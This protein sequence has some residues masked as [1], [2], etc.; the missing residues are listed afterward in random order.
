MILY[1]NDLDS[2]EA[3]SEEVTEE[4]TEEV[5]EDVSE[6]STQEI[7]TEGDAYLIV[8]QEELN[9]AVETLPKLYNLF[10]FWFLCWIFVQVLLRIRRQFH[11]HT[12]EID[13]K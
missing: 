9:L 8:S 13:D 11:R 5:T 4:I 6:D 3:T 1:L 2:T 7:A 10:S 12:N